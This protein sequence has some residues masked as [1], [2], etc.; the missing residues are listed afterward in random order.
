MLYD[1]ENTRAVANAL[2]AHY[3]NAMPP[4]VCD[5][6]CVST[7]GHRLLHPE[8]VEV[9]VKEIFPLTSLITPN[10]S[11]AELLLAHINLPSKIENMADMLA[12]VENLATLVPNAVLLK[13]GHFTTSTSE[14]NVLSQNHPEIS[15]IGDGILGENMEIL[16]IA[17][18]PSSPE[19]LVVDLLYE[20]KDKITMILQSRID[21]TSTHGT[22]CTLS[23]AIAC[24]LGSGLTRKVPYR[25]QHYYWPNSFEFRQ[26]LMQL[27][28]LQAIHILGL[29]RPYRWARVVARSIICIPYPR[30]VS[31]RELRIYSTSHI[32]LMKT[33]GA[34]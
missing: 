28:A 24:G 31:H 18:T 14:I 1:A 19:A 13:G 9:M 33:P 7:S 32:I 3:P 5:P 2:R 34:H 8:A 4:L 23:A 30:E 12:A 26:C 10:K 27:K 25:C 29:K 22:G 21:S 6:V 20:S 16:K 17:Q 15:I 11:E